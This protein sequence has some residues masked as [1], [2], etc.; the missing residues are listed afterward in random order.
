MLALWGQLFV[1]VNLLIFVVT[2]IPVLEL[3][4]TVY[5]T[6]EVCSSELKVRKKCARKTQIFI[7][8][9]GSASGLKEGPY[10]SRRMIGI[11][12]AVAIGECR[13]N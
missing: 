7:S 9:N 6:P 5:Q 8:E 1:I 13:P 3:L 2:E 4:L 11:S 10:G 12:S